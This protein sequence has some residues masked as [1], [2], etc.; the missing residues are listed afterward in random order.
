[1]ALT[2]FIFQ[3]IHIQYTDDAL[4]NTQMLNEYICLEIKGGAAF[5]FQ[6]F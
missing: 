6:K 5:P 2:L 3:L 4:T 1:L